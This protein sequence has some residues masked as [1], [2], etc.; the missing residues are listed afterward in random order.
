M[1]PRE[2]YTILPEPEHRWCR[3]GRWGWGTAAFLACYILFMHST[4]W[5]ERGQMWERW[6]TTWEQEWQVERERLENRMSGV[7]VALGQL[8]SRVPP[9]TSPERR[10][11]VKPR[12]G[13]K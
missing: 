5:T 4:F 10:K 2:G 1:K 7:Q 11:W 6:R 9:P 8:E 12:W 13:A 3:F